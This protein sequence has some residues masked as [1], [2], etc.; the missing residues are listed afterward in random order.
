M[1]DAH[2]KGKINISDYWSV[3]DT[4]I[5]SLNSIAS[6]NEDLFIEDW[7]YQ[8]I[9]IVITAFDQY[10][11]A[12]VNGTRSK[13]ALVCQTREVMNEISNN[14]ATDSCA[15]GTIF[16]NLNSDYNTDYENCHWST[17][18][19]RTWMNGD[20]LKNAFD[21]DIF[22]NLI[23]PIKRQVL[24]TRGCSGTTSNGT[25]DKTTE[26]VIDSIFLPTYQEICG[27]T[28][29]SDYMSGITPDGE[30]GTQW[31]YYATSSNRVKYGNGGGEQFS[32]VP[33][34]WWTGS[35]STDY[36]TPQGDDARLGCTWYYVAEDGD[37]FSYPARV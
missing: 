24:A 29:D 9:T 6:P 33:V 10:D 14:G 20:F 30:E 35:P 17:I 2:Y 11:L 18:A 7:P 3:G 8:N 5:I 37:L 25:V 12:T 1:L 23:K 22:T 13:C 31:T 32:D 4:R 36:R 27:N 26:T 28:S 16:V 21:S 19:M 34:Y 15:E